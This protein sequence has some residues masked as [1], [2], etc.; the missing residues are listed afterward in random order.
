MGPHV[1]LEK[2]AQA[3]NVPTQAIKNLESSWGLYSLWPNLKDRA[4]TLAVSLCLVKHV[5]KILRVS[6]GWRISMFEFSFPRVQCILKFH[7]RSVSLL[8]C[9]FGVVCYCGG[10]VLF[11]W[12]D[13]SQLPFKYHHLGF[14]LF[15]DK[16]FLENGENNCLWRKTIMCNFSITTNGYPSFFT[17]LF[18]LKLFL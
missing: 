13:R 9:V 11:D 12:L 17:N 14:L 16:T 18:V 7:T 8:L 2:T 6:E 10:F 3:S 5:L 15:L 4:F 1:W